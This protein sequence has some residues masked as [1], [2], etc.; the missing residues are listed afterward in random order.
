MRNRRR[1]PLS[2]A[3]ARYWKNVV[4]IACVP[5]AMV[6]VGVFALPSWWGGPLLGILFLGACVVAAFPY[7]FKDAP[8]SFWGFSIICFMAGGLVA[9]PVM[10]IVSR[11]VHAGN[12]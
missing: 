6:I 1:L 12:G 9:I 11:V 7:L 10:L 2:Q 5:S 4:P 3:V 8:Y